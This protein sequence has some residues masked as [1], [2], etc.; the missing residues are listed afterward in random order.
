MRQVETVKRLLCGSR[1]SGGTRR[2]RL[3]LQIGDRAF[4]PQI[5]TQEF[6][7]VAAPFL[8]KAREA[9]LTSLKFAASRRGLQK[10]NINWIIL[11]GGT[12]QVLGIDE[13]LRG[14]FGPNTVIS[15]PD[16]PWECVAKGACAFAEDPS[17]PEQASGAT[18]GV[19]SAR[20][21]RPNDSSDRV[22]VTSYGQS[23]C[24]YNSIFFVRGQKVPAEG[25][26]Q[27]YTTIEDRQDV[28][29]FNVLRGD[30][31]S[32]AACETVG[33]L[34][35]QV[36]QTEHGYLVHCKFQIDEG[37]RLR[38]TAWDPSTKRTVDCEIEWAPARLVDAN[39]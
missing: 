26:I 10:E 19:S 34:V 6:A 1:G 9:V 24:R 23:K 16:D 37:N 33:S 32:P 4:V 14:I 8:E 30:S 21:A 28:I 38:V 13:L 29:A 15:M 2:E 11:T 35:L 27:S 22:F 18:Y 12:S 5:N 25:I 36:P 39:G 20:D 3:Q 31:D 7:Q 17:N